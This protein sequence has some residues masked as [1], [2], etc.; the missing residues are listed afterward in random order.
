MLAM[1]PT[2]IN[3]PGRRLEIVHQATRIAKAQ[4]AA[5]PQGL[6]DQISDFAPPALTAR[7]ARVVFATGLLHRLPPFNVTISNVPGPNV[8]VYLCG[9]RLLAHYPVSVVTGGQGLNITLV[10]YL[11][12]LNFGLVSCR[13]LVPDLD[14]LAGYLVDELDLLLEAAEKRPARAPP[15][16]ARRADDAL[17]PA[18]PQH[19][20]RRRRPRRPPGGHPGSRPG[21]AGDLR[22]G[23]GHLRGRAAAG[24]A[25]PGPPHRRGPGHPVPPGRQPGAAARPG[26]VV[27]GPPPARRSRAGQRRPDWDRPAQRRD[28]RRA[29][30]HRRRRP[31]ARLPGG[32]PGNGAAPADRGPQHRAPGHG[33]R[34]AEPHR[35]GTRPRLVRRPPGHPDPGLRDPAGQRGVPVLRRD[36]RPGPGHQ[37][38]RHRHR[39][40]AARP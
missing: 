13:E 7:A 23:R 28:R 32:R 6:V 24:H 4:Q 30:R 8:P 29:A 19:R 17:G 14:A 34:A 18:R 1:L 35:P 15:T 25:V 2:N 36:R 11:G 37:P 40:P 39:G 3:E 20:R 10:G 22:R 31:A 12:K 5:I 16:S 26:A 38:G 21:P 33:R 27:A 9:A